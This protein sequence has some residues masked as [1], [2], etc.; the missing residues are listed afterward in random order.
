[1]GLFDHEKL[2]V[3]RAS[4]EFAGWSYRLGKSLKGPDRH[5]RDQILRASQSIPLNIAE[6][7]S[8]ITTPDRRRFFRIALGSAL[9]CAAT[10]DV[11]VVCNLISAEYAQEGKA[12]LD[13]IVAMLTGLSDRQNAY[14]GRKD[15]ERRT[16]R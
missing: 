3:Y 6:G 8:K 14:R 7:N 1:M 5:A 16:R 9:E 13:R 4:L 2:A 10:L 15:G 12:R 11:L